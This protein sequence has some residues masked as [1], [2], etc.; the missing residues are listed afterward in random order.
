MAAIPIGYYCIDEDGDAFTDTWSL[1][2]EL[3]KKGWG[4]VWKQKTKRTCFF[5]LCDPAEPE[6]LTDIWFTSASA[7]IWCS[8]LEKIKSENKLYMAI[9]KEI[10]SQ[11]IY[12][13]EGPHREIPECPDH[14]RGKE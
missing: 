11:D 1:D 4:G 12:E 7:L 5:F 14:L 3:K 10:G 13:I 8:A 2:E 6:V 9:V